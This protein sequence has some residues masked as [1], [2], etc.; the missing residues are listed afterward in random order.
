ME[1]EHHGD[2]SIIVSTFHLQDE[3]QAQCDD[4]VGFIAKVVV[5]FCLK[6]SLTVWSK[7]RHAAMVFCGHPRSRSEQAWN[8][9]TIVEWTT[10]DVGND[11][12]LHIVTLD[13]ETQIYG[14]IDTR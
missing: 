6:L 10:L 4:I 11:E 2:L 12:V 14:F 5:H 3:I 7:Y 1:T 8:N 13:E 9:W